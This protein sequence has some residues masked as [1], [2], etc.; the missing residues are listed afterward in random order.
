[1]NSLGH[2]GNGALQG[3]L[4]GSTIVA[5][6]AAAAAA[7]ASL[8][9]SGLLLAASPA[10]HYQQMMMAG[11]DEALL[12]AAGSGLLPDAASA[13]CGSSWLNSNSDPS[14]L[15]SLTASGRQL[16][17]TS[18]VP[19][20]Q[21]YSAGSAAGRAFRSS[22]PAAAA[23][24]GMMGVPLDQS[25]AMAAGLDGSMLS[26]MQGMPLSHQLSGSSV[27]L[28]GAAGM[29]GK[30]AGLAG[31]AP[32]GFSMLGS[33]LS[34]SAYQQQL[35]QQLQMEQHQQQQQQQQQ[36]QM[37]QQQLLQD[38]LMLQQQLQALI[39]Q[40]AMAAAS[41]SSSSLQQLVQQQQAQLQLQQMA[42][43]QAAQQQQ[44]WHSS[45]LASQPLAASA[46]ASQLLWQQQQQ[47]EASQMQHGSY[48]SSSSMTPP[49]GTLASVLAG[50]GAKPTSMM[51]PTQ[52]VACTAPPAYGLGQRPGQQQGVLKWSSSVLSK[53]GSGHAG[54][55]SGQDALQHQASLEASGSRD[56]AVVG[57][58]GPAAG[59]AAAGGGMLQPAGSAGV[60]GSTTLDQLNG[61][62]QMVHVSSSSA[63][64]G[65]NGQGF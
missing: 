1:M 23:A 56:G 15:N 65:P 38:Q 60:M 26:G 42:A 29:A 32:A 33:D 52:Q 48:G 3:F 16:S 53:R 4:Q 10:H 25:A 40:Q 64:S 34:G 59:G 41:A 58:L 35:L 2:A 19:M 14:L 22:L 43:A 24:A 30:A 62:L 21:P 8:N 36:Q 46:P 5:A 63:M 27:S 55:T 18:P 57:L 28:A 45:M 6:A 61:L 9:S 39:Q 31:S 20:P 51:S 12:Q 7:A 54:S 50:V 17:A 11:G 13:L 49:D 44:Q 37:S 47:L